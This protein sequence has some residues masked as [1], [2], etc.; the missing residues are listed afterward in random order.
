MNVI[1]LHGALVRALDTPGLRG[2]G[3]DAVRADL[4]AVCPDDA[5]YDRVLGECVALGLVRVTRFRVVPTD[6][7][8]DFLR[9]DG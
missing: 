6:T 4:R 2:R 3:R 5:E 1:G 9:G 7:T 8:R